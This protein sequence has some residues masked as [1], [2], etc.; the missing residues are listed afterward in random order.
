MIVQLRTSFIPPSL[1]FWDKL[2]RGNADT[3]IQ[4]WQQ[5]WKSSG[6]GQL[7]FIN[8][9]LGRKLDI[10]PNTNAV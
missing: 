3:D 1:L 9:D 8:R 6:S 5:F 2:T 4:C 7:F 10:K